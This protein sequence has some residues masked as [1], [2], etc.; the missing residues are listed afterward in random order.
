MEPSLNEN[1]AGLS[2][3]PVLSNRDDDHSSQG[4][5]LPV[6]ILMVAVML[7]LGWNL[8]LA[9]TQAVTWQ[10]QITQR[11]QLVNQ[12]RSV[13]SDLQKIASDLISLSLTDVDARLIVEKYQIKQ[14]QNAAVS[15]PLKR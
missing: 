9:K 6:A 5:F 3:A 4:I 14:D 13:Q 12:A 2:G 15:P 11:E 7:M 8:Y 1:N 10:K